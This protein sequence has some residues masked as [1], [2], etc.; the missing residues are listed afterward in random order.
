[1]LKPASLFTDGAVLCR[2]KEIRIF[3]EV[4]GGR[5][6]TVRLEDAAGRTL[7]EAAA[8]EQ[9]GRF[10]ALLRPQE[11]QAGCRLTIRAG[12]ECAEARDV[13]VG[14]V[15]LAG[16]QSNMELELRNA[17]EGPECLRE[18][19]DPLLRFFNVPRIAVEGP[20]LRKAAE[21]ARWQP[22]RPGTGGESSAVAWFF[23]RKIRQRNPEIPVGI[24]GCYWGGTSV[25]CWTEEETL[26]TD[27][28]GTRYL[29]EYAAQSA[30]K[31][32]ETYL[33]EEKRFQDT[34]GA[35]NRK[36]EEFRQA[37][38]GAAWKEIEAACG[39]APWNPPAGP[40]S[41][42]RPGGLARTMVAQAAPFALTAVLFYQGEEDTWRTEHYD[43][44][45]IL[46]IRE[47][48]K[49]FRDAELPFLFVQLPMWLDW[50]AE[51]T[52]R[53]AA[54]RLAQAAVRD[55]VRNTGMVC[56]LDQG[57]Y[58]NIHPAVKRPVGERLAELAG[59]M[60]YGKGEVSP[61]ARGKYTEGETLTVCLSAPVRIPEGGKACLLE[62]AGETGAYV[63]AEAEILGDRLRL[64]ADGIRFPVR[65]RYAW[66]DY[67]DR[68]NLFGE[69]GLPLEPF[70]L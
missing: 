40:G 30:G 9:N 60:L 66:T 67:S 49:R 24:I 4:S 23:A 3:G 38:P 29:E 42:Y 61:R 48:R 28:E 59:S 27:A 50:G 63:P 39:Y 35:W 47:W 57:E 15:F 64:R 56:L 46:L 2:R 16:G 7:A 34:M 52:F 22:V 31:S 13:A 19:E 17:R 37:H 54:L 43:R 18:A 62:I 70:D 55:T 6:V 12:E 65:A 25:T 58:G 36:M 1:M 8:E 26:R 69:N 51:D 45:M 41:P 14:D 20:A 44:L 53:W 10:L 68:V 32:M 11:A 5:A 33:E 21:E